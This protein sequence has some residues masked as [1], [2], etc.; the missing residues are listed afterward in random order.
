MYDVSGG[1]F[2]L[3][4]LAA[5]CLIL[6][7][8]CLGYRCACGMLSHV[9]AVCK[10][11]VCT[12]MY[13]VQYVCVS[14]CVCVS[15]WA[16]LRACLVIFWRL[17]LACSSLFFLPLEWGGARGGVVYRC[18][19]VSC[20]GVGVGGIYHTD[21]AIGAMPMRTCAPYMYNKGPIK[22]GQ[23]QI[24]RR[25]GPWAVLWRGG[26]GMRISTVYV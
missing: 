3:L 26:S 7:P 14:A 15:C 16:V 6:F 10:S 23:G 21:T 20:R 4:A 22:G 25:V 2:L 13:R 11:R 19:G 9:G 17:V 12:G 24:D 5:C 1:L 18:S 8:E